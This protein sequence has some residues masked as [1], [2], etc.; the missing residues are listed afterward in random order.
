MTPSVRV[1]GGGLAGSEA[2]LTLARLGIPVELWE[3]RPLRG[4]D[5]HV[6]DRFGELVCS[7]SLGSDALKDARGLLKAEL[8]TLGSSV[9][10]CADQSSCRRARRL[11]WT[12][13]SS[14]CSSL[15][16]LPGILASL[17]AARSTRTWM[18]RGR[19]SLP[20]GR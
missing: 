11:Q 15:R 18:R 13:T 16:R 4:T 19:Q 10:A 9:M 1:V 5:V 12:A 6:T 17:C 14:A 20:R 8:R 7:N 3:M 2:A